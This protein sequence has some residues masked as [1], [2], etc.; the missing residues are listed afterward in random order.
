MKRV[1]VTL[2]LWK[3]KTFT[4]SSNIR[5]HENVPSGSQVVPRGQTDGQA[6]MTILVAA[7]RNFVNASAI[8]HA[9]RISK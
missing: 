7:F 8:R 6:D 1:R 4:G 5:F 9:D 3:S 2:L